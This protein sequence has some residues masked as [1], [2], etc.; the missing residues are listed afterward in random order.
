MATTLTAGGTSGVALANLRQI[1]VYRTSL[2]VIF[3]Y[4]NGTTTTV[5][6]ADAT[7]FI[8]N[9]LPYFAANAPVSDFPNL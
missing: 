8:T 1:T 2:K 9:A 4:I 5:S 6:G 7:D 3:T